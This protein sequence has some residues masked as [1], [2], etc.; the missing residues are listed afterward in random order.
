M[1]SFA[2]NEKLCGSRF[3]YTLCIHELIILTALLWK[4]LKK[5]FSYT[6]NPCHIFRS[7]CFTCLFAVWLIFLRSND[8]KNPFQ[9]SITLIRDAHF[10]NE[11]HFIAFYTYITTIWI[12]DVLRNAVL[13]YQLLFDGE[14]LRTTSGSVFY[15]YVHVSDDMCTELGVFHRCNVTC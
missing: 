4:K 1:Y 8:R 10:I 15:A 3:M 9:K 14:L 2:T 12:S 5:G 11:V 13:C 6:T 7:W